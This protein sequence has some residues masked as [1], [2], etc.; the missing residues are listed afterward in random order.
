VDLYI[1]VTCTVCKGT[2]ATWYGNHCPYCSVG[3]M[4]VAVTKQNLLN[5]I[6][7]FEKEDKYKIFKTLKEDIENEN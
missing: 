6:L 5:Y 3:K 4:Y 7:E 1:K 2:E